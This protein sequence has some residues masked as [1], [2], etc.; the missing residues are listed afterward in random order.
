MRGK[1]KMAKKQNKCKGVNSHPAWKKMWLIYCSNMW[2]KTT[3]LQLKYYVF[4]LI[5]ELLNVIV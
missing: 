1:E 4:K 3:H 2:M 5:D